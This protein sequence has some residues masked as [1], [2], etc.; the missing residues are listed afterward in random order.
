[1]SKEGV[2]HSLE[3]LF[4]PFAVISGFI[5]ARN[6]NEPILF[7][8]IRDAVHTSLKIL[9]RPQDLAVFCGI[10]NDKTLTLFWD[11]ADK[12]SYL[13][14]PTQTIS[15]GSKKR[16]R[17][18]P[19]SS[20]LNHLLDVFTERLN[21]LLHEAGGDTVKIDT[22][23]KGL[24]ALHMPKSP[25]QLSGTPVDATEL[26]DSLRSADFYK[27]QI[28][29]GATLCVPASK[30]KMAS[31]NSQI[32]KA[33]WDALKASRNID[34]LFV[35][36]AQSI[37]HTGDVVLSTS[38]ASGKSLVYQ[39]AALQLLLD[40]PNSRV[41]LVF[42][43]KALAQDQL[44]SITQLASK[45]HGLD[46]QITVMDGD[47]QERDAVSTASVILTNP[48]TLHMVLPSPK[49][50]AVW[51]NLR[52]VVLDELHVYQGQMGQHV[53]HILARLQRLILDESQ[54]R[55]IG[56]SA[57][58]AN[59]QAHMQMLTGRSAH[60]ISEDG[61]PRGAKHLVL[62][63][64][65][66]RADTARISAHLLSR[67]A[68]T[69]IFCKFR[70]LCELV[71]HEILDHLDQT[72]RLRTLKSFV[73]SYRAGYTVQE[74]RNIERALFDGQTRL[75]VATSALELGIDIGA[76]DVV[77]TVGVPVTMAA[78]W[79]QVGRA[80]RRNQDSLAIVIATTSS[81][82]RQMVKSQNVFKRTVE[83]AQVSQE[84]SIAWSHLQCA[85]FELPIDCNN[86]ADAKMLCRI[87]GT[88][89]S[90]SLLKSQS[91]NPLRFD[92]ITGK[93][94]CALSY[95]PWPA[96]KVP[97]RSIRQTDWQVVQR[98]QSGSL[99]LLEE[100]DSWHAIFTLYEGG[101]F[102][103]RGRTFS[104]ELVDV[105]AQIAL[106]AEASVSWY[107]EQRDYQ[108]VIPIEPQKATSLANPKT[109]Y[110]FGAVEVKA[111]VFGYRRKDIRTK[112]VLE[113]V[114]HRSPSL[115][116]NSFGVWIDIPISVTQELS[117]NKYDVEASVHAAQHAMLVEV[118]KL[119]G[120]MLDDLA[121]ECKSPMA[122]RSK[123]P[124]L[125][126]YEKAAAPN[127]PTMRSVAVAQ[128]IMQR[129]MERVEKCI[130]KENTKLEANFD[131]VGGCTKCILL[132][133][134]SEHNEC[135]NK[136]GALLILKSI[137][138]KL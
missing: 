18:L 33:I 9:L 61:A 102:L 22:V 60:V 14:D 20:E 63:D 30:A 89:E 62:W 82:D 5:S 137:C 25:L 8:T 127:G 116:T 117:K 29:D 125:V 121:T 118:S 107:T 83:Q 6:G 90:L 72:P 23:L 51:S 93:W 10:L 11:D 38:T 40:D 42:P 123:T 54:V 94:V 81:I 34:Q 3:K 41:L 16:K 80:G 130:C 77:L 103:H 86:D 43:T 24:E 119:V 12:L 100:L 17:T 105:D 36:Q 57:T 47:T 58:T 114:E 55:F 104:I 7:D 108:T 74:R 68:R 53:A 27:S 85:A 99:I 92:A 124:R 37:N 45:T 21:K 31:P 78:L 52:L 4:K 131:V 2:V 50:R 1:M 88:N 84:P 136:K 112:Q 128:T 70:K 120:C 113:I 122:T 69:I 97:I 65:M 71:C 66:G 91:S 106:V 79:Q 48:D 39:I 129:A 133:S 56:C 28:I 73:M 111:T 19:G 126:I 98:T 75:V 26:L 46:I 76:L 95:K 15:S 115:S 138:Q 64:S 35:H 96:A 13:L 49:W 134:C 67:G 109:Q 132:A 59:P 110:I 87:L 32:H 101:I 44:A 135:I